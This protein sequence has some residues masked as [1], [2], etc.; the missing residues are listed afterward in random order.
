MV[1]KVHIQCILVQNFP[2]ACSN[3]TR[4]YAHHL[5]KTRGS[6]RLPRV[7]RGLGDYRH[8]WMGL[9]MASC[10]TWSM[11]EGRIIKLL[12]APEQLLTTRRCRSWNRNEHI[13]QEDEEKRKIEE[14]IR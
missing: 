9:E 12:V 10:F 3:A 7:C 13:G 2:W 4:R 5:E 6:S 11:D 14:E 8:G 1:W